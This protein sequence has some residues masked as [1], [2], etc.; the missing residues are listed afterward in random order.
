MSPRMLLIAVLALLPM[1]SLPV[2]WAAEMPAVLLP[3]DGEVRHGMRE[4]R[5]LVEAARIRAAEGRMDAEAWGKLGDRLAHQ[6]QKI[7]NNRLPADVRARVGEL[8]ARLLAAVAKVRA[9]GA[10]GLAEVAA[11]VEE[12]RRSFDHPGL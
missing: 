7:T 3:T 1:A 9:S 10:D 5:E 11:L 6:A 2:A 8:S 4:I 12:Y